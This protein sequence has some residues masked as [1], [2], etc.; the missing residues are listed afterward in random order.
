M[1]FNGYLKSYSIDRS[2]HSQIRQFIR[3]K[4][5]IKQQNH[6]YEG[7]GTAKKSS[8]GMVKLNVAVW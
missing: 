6:V 4:M 7:W 5:V 3:N 1:L 2:C 8:I